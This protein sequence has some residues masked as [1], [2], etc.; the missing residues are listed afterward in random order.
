M[1]CLV[2]EPAVGRAQV[3]AAEQVARVALVLQPLGRPLGEPRVLIEPRLVELERVDERGDARVEAVLSAGVDPV[4]P[5]EGRRQRQAVHRPPQDGDDAL[6]EIHRSL[7]LLAADGRRQRVRRE[8]EDDDLGGLDPRPYVR[9]PVR[10]AAADVLDVEPDLLAA[11][12]ERSRQP[13]LDEVAVLA[14]VR[15]KHVRPDA[16]CRGGLA[17]EL[18]H[19]RLPNVTPVVWPSPDKHGGAARAPAAGALLRYFAVARAL[20]PAP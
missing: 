7:Q 3:A 5:F 15:E 18:R 8:H 10:G 9:P 19:H 12:R 13:L 6:V 16:G 20:R 17:R 14:R 1:P 11:L 2:V 4:R